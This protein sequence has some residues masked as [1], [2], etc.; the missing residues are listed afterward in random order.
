[1]KKYFLCTLIALI[2]F[3]FMTYA[4]TDLKI[5][6]LRHGE[7]P[8]KGNNLTCKGLNRSLMLP[9]LLSKKFGVPDFVYVPALTLGEKTKHARM[10][11]TVTPLAVKYNLNIDSKFEEMDSTGIATDIKQRKGTVLVV[12]EHKALI[13]IIHALG[14][15]YTTPW[16]GD[17]YDT[18]III[19]Y[20]DGKPTLTLDSEGL[21]PS[22]DCPN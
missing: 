13:S 18:I 1:M 22:D 5:V 17:D 12:W 8:E 6:F 15:Q 4:Q 9:A 20:K 11:E 16:S 10:F 14:I 2:G 3:G 7:K 19:T 21:K